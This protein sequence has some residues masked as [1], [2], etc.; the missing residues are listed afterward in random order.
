MSARNHLR[1]GKAES[2]RFS[3]SLVV[4]E[5][6]KAVGQWPNG[7]NRCDTASLWRVASVWKVRAMVVARFQIPCRFVGKSRGVA[8]TRLLALAKSETC[9]PR[10]LPVMLWD[11]HIMCSASKSSHTT[12]RSCWEATICCPISSR[13]SSKSELFRPGGKNEDTRVASK[14]SV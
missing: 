7:S 13:W 12:K 6:S 3:S 11:G 1:R 5:I 8:S 4:L 10:P 14:F 9:C 2:P